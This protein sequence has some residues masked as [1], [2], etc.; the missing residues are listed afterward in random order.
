MAKRFCSRVQLRSLPNINA[1][2]RPWIPIVSADDD[3]LL[4]EHG[5]LLD[6]HRS[7]LYDN[8]R[9]YNGGLPIPRPAAPPT[10]L[11][12]ATGRKDGQEYHYQHH[13]LEHVKVSL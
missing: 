3:R 12:V 7:R 10:R 9:N 2:R 1:T 8:G 11:S 4:D 5:A 13:F 6:Y